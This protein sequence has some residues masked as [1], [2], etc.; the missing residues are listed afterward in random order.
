MSKNYINLCIKNYIYK[1]KTLFLTSTLK[2]SID[3]KYLKY[4]KY[5]SY[6]LSYKLILSINRSKNNFN[7]SYSLYKRYRNPEKT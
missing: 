6:K 2:F 5:K 1:I 7:F 3:L 4:L